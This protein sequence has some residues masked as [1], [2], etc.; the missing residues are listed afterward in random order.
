MPGEPHILT[1]RRTRSLSRQGRFS[2]LDSTSLAA[3]PVLHVIV[4]ATRAAQDGPIS[5][6]DVT[7]S[8]VMPGATDRHARVVRR[9][10]QCRSVIHG[11]LSRHTWQRCHDSRRRANGGSA[12]RQQ[13][14]AWTAACVQLASIPSLK[15]AFDPAFDE[16]KRAASLRATGALLP[17]SA[18]A[19]LASAGQGIHAFY[20][21]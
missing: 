2:R 7:D 16:R 13:W 11:E 18:F 17:P 8:S 4:L 12:A 6:Q 14:H 10:H 21:L 20:F 1:P 5:N 15:L 9:K 19:A 3:L